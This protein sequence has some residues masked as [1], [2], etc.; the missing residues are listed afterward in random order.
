MTFSEIRRREPGSILVRFG[1]I[2]AERRIPAIVTS[3]QRFASEVGTSSS[4]EPS[5]LPVTEKDFAVPADFGA[6]NAGV[7]APDRG[8]ARAALLTAAPP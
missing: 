4:P 5:K 8:S 7:I 3:R 2:D 1:E 6:R